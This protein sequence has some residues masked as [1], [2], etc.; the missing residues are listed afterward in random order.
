M[1]N[2]ISNLLYD[3]ITVL[4]AKAKGVEAYDQYLRDAQAE[5]S[6]ECID[7]LS[8]LRDQDIRTIE[9]ISRHVAHLF[10]EEFGTGTSADE[11]VESSAEADADLPHAAPPAEPEPRVQAQGIADPGASL[12]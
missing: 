4:H 10:H 1:K 7:L 8:R 9:E 2:P 11:D 6:R 5:N 12:H 3:W